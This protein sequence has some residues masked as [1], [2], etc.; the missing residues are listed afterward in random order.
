MNR[1][2]YLPTFIKYARKLLAPC[3]LIRALLLI[4]CRAF[5]R[6][7]R[8]ASGSVRAAAVLS[9]ATAAV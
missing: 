1:R 8:Q 4:P 7:T 5:T 9:R 6:A 3:E 2:F